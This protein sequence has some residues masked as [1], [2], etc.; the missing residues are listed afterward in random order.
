MIYMIGFWVGIE[1]IILIIILSSLLGI[2]VGLVL[3]VLNK[4]H[5]QDYLPYGCFIST[6]SLVLILL[7]LEFNFSSMLLIS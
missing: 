4:I 7:K 5:S 3:V 2:F 6:A 1:S